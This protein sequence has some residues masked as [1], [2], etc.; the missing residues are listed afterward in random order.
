MR[1]LTRRIAVR[2]FASLPVLGELQAQ[3]VLDDIC[4]A[5]ASLTGVFD[6]WR[7]DIDIS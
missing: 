6:V 7:C 1:Y 3:A 4:T 2:T 5:T